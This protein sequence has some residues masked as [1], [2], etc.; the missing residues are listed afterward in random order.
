MYQKKEPCQC[1]LTPIIDI[2][3]LLIIF[4]MIVCSFIA[5]E[6]FD[7]TVPDRI[8]TAQHVDLDGPKSTTVSVMIED[9]GKVSYAVGARKM[10]AT[11][12]DDLSGE[13]AAA[14]DLQL[15]EFGED[16]KI[17][18]LRIDKDVPYRCSQHALAAVSRSSA[19]D[20]MLAVIKQ[21]NPKHMQ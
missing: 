19:T 8:S 6:N 16:E 21:H 5:A 4:F 7:V 2:V 18:S 17:V 20:I 13:I 15:A 10:T 14:I 11:G 3:F 1:N 12:G 9:N